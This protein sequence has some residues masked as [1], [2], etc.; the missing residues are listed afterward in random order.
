VDDAAV[1]LHHLAGCAV[2]G[3]LVVLDPLAPQP[4]G[5]GAESPLGRHDLGDPGASRPQGPSEVLHQRHEEALPRLAGRTLEDDLQGGLDLSIGDRRAGRQ[6]VRMLPRFAVPR[7]FPS[8][9]P[10]RSMRR[11]VMTV[12]QAVL[13]VT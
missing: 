6:H 1:F 13:I 4:E 2:D 3:V 12:A 7:S 8:R 5:E 11:F 9:T 10:R